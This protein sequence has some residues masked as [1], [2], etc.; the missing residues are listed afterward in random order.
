MGGDLRK[1]IAL[2][3]QQAPRCVETYDI[4]HAVAT[5]LQAH[6]RAHAP[7]HAFLQQAGTTLPRFQQTDLAFL[8]HN[9]SVD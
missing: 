5:Q 2:F 9:S 3:R 4:S 8:L 6:W 7:W 1:G